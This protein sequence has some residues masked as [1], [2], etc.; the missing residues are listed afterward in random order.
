MRYASST[1]NHKDSTN[2]YLWTLTHTYIVS[3]IGCCGGRGGGGELHR[4]QSL[5][6]YIPHNRHHRNDQYHFMLIQP[7]CRDLATAAALIPVDTV[8]VIY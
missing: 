8:P 5:V 4:V 2:S 3:N 6:L 7:Y 1:D